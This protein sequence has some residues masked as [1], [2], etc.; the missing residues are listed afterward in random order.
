MRFTHVR[1]R[2]SWKK[3]LWARIKGAQDSGKTFLPPIISEGQ[4]KEMVDGLWREAKNEMW[5]VRHKYEVRS[6][7][8]FQSRDFELRKLQK[9]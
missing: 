1:L 4:R 3:G 2:M 5:L 8:I 6:M 9:K 7:H